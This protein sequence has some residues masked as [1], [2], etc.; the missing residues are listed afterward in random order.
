MGGQVDKWTDGG[1]QGV[2]GGGEGGRNEE[3][4]ILSYV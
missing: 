3:E 1:R 2:E 4:K